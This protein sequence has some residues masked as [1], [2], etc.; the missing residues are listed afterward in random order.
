MLW[1]R[2]GSFLLLASLSIPVVQ[3]VD[4]PPSEVEMK[5]VQVAEH[6]YY[7]QGMAGT[8]TENEGFISN[9]GIVITD[10][11]VVVIDALG[12]PSLAQLLMQQV[13]KVTDKPVVKMIVTHYHADH[14]YGLQYFKAMGVEVIA[15]SGAE[16]YLESAAAQERL[17]ERRFSLEPW[18]NEDTHLVWPDRYVEA[19]L[20]LDIGGVKFR[21]TVIGDAH[22]DADMSVYVE[23][24]RVLYSGDVIF[25]GRIPFLGSANTRLWLKALD[26]MDSNELAALVP[27]HG[28]HQGAPVR[29][30]GMTHRYLAILRQTMGA[31]VEELMPFDEVYAA[32]DWSEFEK[33]PAFAAGHRRN[34]YQ[35]YL[36]MEKELLAE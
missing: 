16:K 15:P 25:E 20:D 35:V 14:V 12:S 3:A 30:L 29:A 18:V 31:A 19:A 21:M 4:Y 9:A 10:A 22:S 17:E 6:S 2:T 27:G 7:V 8:A 33:L 1:F 32:T 24:D 34:A 5:L 11:G 13:R 36:S 23:N 26:E 28:P